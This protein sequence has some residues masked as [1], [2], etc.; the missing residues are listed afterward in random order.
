[1]NVVISEKLIEDSQRIDS[2]IRRL[3]NKLS[4]VIDRITDKNADPIEIIQKYKEELAEIKTDLKEFL[5]QQEEF[6]RS[7]LDAEK[8][9]LMMAEEVKKMMTEHNITVETDEN[10]YEKETQ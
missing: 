8:E 3:Q 2:G 7:I 10:N 4:D 9:I 5:I 1:M 6:D